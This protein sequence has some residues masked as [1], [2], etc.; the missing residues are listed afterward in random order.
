MLPV[1]LL[2]LSVSAMTLDQAIQAA[3]E[4]SPA[5]AVSQAKVDEA[6]A[7]VWEVSAPLLPS[8]SA[9]VGGVYQTETVFDLRSKLEELSVPLDLSSLTPS[10]IQPESQWIGSVQG[11]QALVAPGAWLAR[12]AAREGLALSEA[13][14]AADRYTLSTLVLQAWHAAAR[15][16]AFEEEAK[17]A[18]ELAESVDEVAQASVDLGVMRQDEIL[19]VKQSIAT[20]RATL[21]RASALV[22]ATDRALKLLTGLD[23]PPD[24]IQVP[25]VVPELDG[26]MA[27]MD[28]ADLAA[29]DARVEAADAL[30]RASMAP[31]L[32]IVGMTGSYTYMDP[33]MFFGERWQYNVK[34]GLTVPLVQGGAVKA[35]MDGARARE[36]QARQG[37]QA[38]REK[39]D[40]EVI[41]AHGLL[42]AAMAAMGEAEEAVRLADHA[43]DVA[44][45]RLGKGGG[46]VFNLD[47][48]QARQVEARIKLLTARSEAAQAWDVLWLIAGQR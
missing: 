22:V 12:G 33:P 20:A 36:E 48:A 46:S 6:R 4:R 37:R 3:V 35:R 34:I 2:C 19:P 11:S 27:F 39:A 14:C 9:T 15:A 21:A 42:T 47:Q 23:G 25:T 32:P 10:V 43:V 26:L 31:A 38:L 16:H 44:Q 18:V 41:Q 13:E 24:A 8:A 1:L 28:R 30:V 40:L 17:R 29:A 7:R 5:L 45:T